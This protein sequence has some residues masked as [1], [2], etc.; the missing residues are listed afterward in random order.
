MGDQEH[1]IN[2][3]TGCHS[4][5]EGEMKGSIRDAQPLTNAEIQRRKKKGE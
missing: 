3:N 5:G 1:S 4:E 2:C